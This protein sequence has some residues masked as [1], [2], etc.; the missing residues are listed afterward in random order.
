MNNS[1]VQVSYKP[2]STYPSE[3]HDAIYDILDD[4]DI[5]EG[6]HMYIFR[7]EDDPNIIAAAVTQAPHIILMAMER[8]E[9]FDLHE[10]S[11]KAQANDIPQMTINDSLGASY[12]VQA[13]VMTAL[14][15]AYIAQLSPG[16]LH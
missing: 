5:Q 15:D 11:K 2:L 3:F 4:F 10:L 6:T 14:I 1:S 13:D 8:K 7:F 9:L 12:T 16:G